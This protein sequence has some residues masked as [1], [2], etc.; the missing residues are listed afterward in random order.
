MPIRLEGVSV[1][2]RTDWELRHEA[3]GAVVSVA[4]M[5]AGSWDMGRLREALLTIS[6]T[7]DGWPQRVALE[8]ANDYERLE[9]IVKELRSGLTVRPELIDEV[10]KKTFTSARQAPPS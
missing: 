6:K 5:I 10:V 2:T 4:V 8:L 3:P 9:E 1:L 7:G